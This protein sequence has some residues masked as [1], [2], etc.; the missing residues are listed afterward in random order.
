MAWAKSRSNRS[1]ADVLKG[2]AMHEATSPVTKNISQQQAISPMNIN[3]TSSSVSTNSSGSNRSPIVSMKRKASLSTGNESKTEDRS[4]Q[5]IHGAQSPLRLS[6]VTVNAIQSEHIP[7]KNVKAIMTSSTA[8]STKITKTTTSSTNTDLPRTPPMKRRP[9]NAWAN[10][11]LSKTASVSSQTQT[12][13]SEEDNFSNMTTPTSIVRVT[14]AGTQTGE[15]KKSDA[16]TSTHKEMVS[17]AAAST[18]DDGNN[19]KNNLKYNSSNKSPKQHFNKLFEGQYKNKG[20]SINARN[21]NSNTIHTSAIVMDDA[22]VKE[23]KLERTGS[24]TAHSGKKTIISSSTTPRGVSK[25]KTTT[26]MHNFRATKSPFIPSFMKTGQELHDDAQKQQPA[27][28]GYEKLYQIHGGAQVKVSSQFIQ[29]LSHEI[30]DFEKF[31]DELTQMFTE[32]IEKCINK[33]KHVIFTTTKSHYTSNEHMYE[34]VKAPV[35]QVHGSFATK[36]WLPSSD[37]DMVVQNLLQSSNG[38][39]KKK[40]QKHAFEMLQNA[41]SM[42]QVIA[43]G[44]EKEDWVGNLMMITTSNMPVIKFYSILN[45]NGIVYKFPFD[46]SIDPGTTP[47]IPGYTHS[48]TGVPAREMITHFLGVMPEFRAM[49]LVLKQL[50]RERGL[51]DTYRGG[52]SSY[53]LA[54]MVTRFLQPFYPNLL[55]GAKGSWVQSFKRDMNKLNRQAIPRHFATYNNATKSRIMGNASQQQQQQS[56][57]EDIWQFNEQNNNSN[58]NNSDKSNTSP[59][60]SNS[61]GNSK[62]SSKSWASM[63]GTKNEDKNPPSSVTNPPVSPVQSISPSLSSSSPTTSQSNDG[64]D[65]TATTAS[66]QEDIPDKMAKDMKESMGAKLLEFLHYFGNHF[67]YLNNGISIRNG[68]MYFRLSQNNMAQGLWID[69]P[70]SPGHNVAISTF[71]AR[72]VLNT[73]RD[74][75]LSCVRHEVSEH[76]PTILSTVIRS[77]PWLEHSLHYAKNCKQEMWDSRRRASPEDYELAAEEIRQEIRKLS[78][79]KQRISAKKEKMKRKMARNVNDDMVGKLNYNQTK[80]PTRAGININKKGNVTIGKS[81]NKNKNKNK[82]RSEKGNGSGGN[83]DTSNIRVVKKKNNNRSMNTTND[84]I[85]IAKN[86]NLAST[87]DGS[88]IS[89]NRRNSKNKSKGTSA[90][91][92]M[93]KAKKKHRAGA[94]Q[95]RKESGHQEMLEKTSNTSTQTG[96]DD[97]ANDKKKGKQLNNASGGARKRMTN[98]NNNNMNQKKPIKPTLGQFYF[99]ALR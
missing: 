31:T 36:L 11:F 67:D 26:K 55:D 49:M 95:K 13:S 75:F 2:N 50:L 25:S 45:K 15:N 38:K 56:M 70:I 52:L 47:D 89:T 28:A 94:T 86:A 72:G 73:F 54:L 34:K 69:D 68:G 82:N 79:E 76:C 21:N 41:T 96:G 29:R 61:D 71:N 30:A 78:L 58:N 53:G 80:S 88:K 20:N 84:N 63:V 5:T 27:D 10:P 57:T 9:G 77:S 4:E 51:N 64:L 6:P 17:T 99:N 98:D 44:L 14:T 35:I 24:T 32:H 12:V 42:L 43:A 33:T 8:T 66:P 91:E 40:S 74:A 39:G 93:A 18:T 7:L 97:I 23:E 92:T 3:A 85:A 22:G 1:F 37:V 83:L 48:H 65:S 19:D 46:V 87:S 90:K 16:G 59:I 81:K 60:N 62:T